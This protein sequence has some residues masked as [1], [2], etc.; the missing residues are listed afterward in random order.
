VQPISDFFAEARG[1]RPSA[2]FVAIRESGSRAGPREPVALA[3]IRGR[4]G[5]RGVIDGGFPT[6]RFGEWETA[7][8]LHQILHL[9]RRE[10]AT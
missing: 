1:K 7:A 9:M 2:L 10:R 6:N 3:F 4:D 8:A 5:S